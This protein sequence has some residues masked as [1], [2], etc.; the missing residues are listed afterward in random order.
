M[1]TLFSISRPH[2]IEVPFIKATFGG[3]D[4]GFSSKKN[5]VTGVIGSNFI[6]SLN[7]EKYG[8]GAVNT[9]T[10]VMKYVI[11]PD[12]DPNFVDMV[13]SKATDRKIFFTYGDISQPEYSYKNEEAIITSIV[14]QVDY[15]NNTIT[16]TIKATS[17]TTLS[18]AVKRTF[19]A[20]TGQPSQEIIKILYNND[21]GLLDLLPGMR[22]KEKVLAKGWIP[23]GDKVVSISEKKDMAPMDY[24][25]YLVS[26][27][28]GSNN[29]YYFL[30]VMDQRDQEQPHFE[31]VSTEQKSKSQMLTIDVGYPGS[32][33]VF[34][35]EVSENSS[36]PLLVEYRDKID[37]GLLKDYS[38]RGDLISKNYYSSETVNGD[39]STNL[40]NW[41]NKMKS[42]PLTATLIT[43]GI[44]VPAEIIQSIYINTYFF[45]KKYWHSGEYLIMSQNDSISEAGYRTTLGLMR[46]GE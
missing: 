25:L 45:G 38:F 31:I 33:T 21:Y 37:S 11:E 27:M 44:Y 10:L 39:Y 17:S 34:N 19:A 36:T 9:Y 20:T 41:W 8:S 29:C 40:R 14:P 22:D 15:K 16:Y 35:F 6:K 24:I 18:Y 23:T 46:I 3:V 5:P 32:V 26:L 1:N 7:V 30:K 42:F 12:D 28:V 13:I 43:Q 2:R 4:F